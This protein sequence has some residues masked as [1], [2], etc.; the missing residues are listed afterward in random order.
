MCGG[1]PALTPDGPRTVAP[2]EGSALRGHPGPWARPRGQLRPEALRL[3]GAD[4]LA[5]RGASGWE[6]TRSCQSSLPG[7]R[8]GLSEAKA[9]ISFC[10]IL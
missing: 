6:L 9:N 2:W 4:R 3:P 8:A 7:C 10:G 5:V 1:S